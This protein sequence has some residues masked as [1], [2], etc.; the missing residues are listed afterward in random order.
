M[1]I[2][3]DMS[4]ACFALD[5][6]LVRERGLLPFQASDVLEVHSAFPVEL[7]D[8][9]RSW[10]GSIQARK[11]DTGQF[12]VLFLRPIAHR[13]TFENDALQVLRYYHYALLLQGAGYSRESLL[14]MG[15]TPESQTGR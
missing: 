15:R 9:W 7:D 2:P 3:P 6:P 8:M 11:F 1:P 10:L 5:G 4:F 13:E 14:I 12:F